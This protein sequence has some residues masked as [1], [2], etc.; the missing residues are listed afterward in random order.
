MAFLYIYMGIFVNFY[1][2]LMQHTL[3]NSF[4]K[5]HCGHF[6]GLKFLHLLFK[7]FSEEVGVQTNVKLI[8]LLYLSVLF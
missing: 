7:I 2:N 3:P 8:D 4:N 1:L 6:S 5:L